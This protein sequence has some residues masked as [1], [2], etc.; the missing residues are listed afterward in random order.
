MK[1]GDFSDTELEQTKSML[2]NQ[3]LE[4]YDTANG[5]AEL[6]Y[7]NVLADK[8]VNVEEWIQKLKQV[9]KEEVIA[10]A[11]KIKENTVYFLSGGEE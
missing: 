10:I 7:H 5:M 9:K 6:M 2:I 4:S 3:L 11:D 1:K 8:N